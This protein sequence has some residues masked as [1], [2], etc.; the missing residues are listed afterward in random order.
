MSCPGFYE[1]LERGHNFVIEVI[2]TKKTPHPVP[3][4]QSY[5]ET[6]DVD[7]DTRTGVNDADYS[8]PFKF[9]GKIAKVTIELEEMK[10]AAA[11]E[12]EKLH[13]EARLKKGLAD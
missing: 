11:D 13:R 6:Y 5:D 10:K 12:A 7:V 8:V 3:F 4:I 1:H 9:T 2:D